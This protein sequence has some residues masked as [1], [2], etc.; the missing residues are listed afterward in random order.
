MFRAGSDPIEMTKETLS[1]YFDR[2]LRQAAS[3]LGIS[4]T[5]LKTLCRKLEVNDPHPVCSERR[6][7]VI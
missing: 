1:Q 3:A 4:A 5:A 2:P 7:S 6:N